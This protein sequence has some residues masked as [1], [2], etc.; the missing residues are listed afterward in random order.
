MSG[1]ETEASVRTAR[2]ERS[3]HI[4]RGGLGAEGASSP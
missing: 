3:V 2:C 4:A 1:R